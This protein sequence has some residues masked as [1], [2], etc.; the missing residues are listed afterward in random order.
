[1]T[2]LEAPYGKIQTAI[3][4]PSAD[5]GDQ[6][7]L[8]IN[9]NRMVSITNVRYT[10]IK[11]KQRDKINCTITMPLNKVFELQAFINL[12]LLEDI[13]L[14]DYKNDIWN[15]K[16]MNN[17]FEHNFFARGEYATIV[18]NFEGVKVH[19]ASINC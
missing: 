16:L 13:K 4:L 8:A 15:V 12:Y 14:T 9:L 1:M 5:F 17:P 6:H 10:Y 2:K 7:G 3:I 19:A 11:R 18:L